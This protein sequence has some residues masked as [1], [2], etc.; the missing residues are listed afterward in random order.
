MI[1]DGL[2]RLIFSS[3]T[4]SQA[5]RALSV[6]IFHRVLSEPDPLFPDEVDVQHFDELLGWIGAGFNV[7]PLTEALDALRAGKLPRRAASI[8][9][10]DGYAD[11]LANAAP[12]LRSH[13]M[14]ATFFIASGFLD[15]GIMFNDVVIESV[16]HHKGENLNLESIGVGIVG[17]KDIEQKRL[18]V[19]LILDKVKFFPQDRRKEAV[20]FIRDASGLIPPR[21]LMLTAD[22]VVQLRQLGMEIGAHTVSH[23]ILSRVSDD[24]ATREIQHGRD[25]LEEILG[26][27][28]RIFAYPNGKRGR[29][30]EEVHAKIVAKSGFDYAVSTDWGV[31][32][33]NSDLFQI[34]RFTPWNRQKSKFN[35][36]LMQNMLKKA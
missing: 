28:V 12:I 6:F 25:R 14:C 36:R 19:N 10:D 20:D 26:E 5:Q 16:R 18:A 13:N 11:N 29:D 27:S 32:R 24:V 31:A 4:V 15:G 35:L 9:F 30:Y 8:T 21:D 23:P 3:L 33:R 1:A 22:G 2:T 7:L 17:T 34:P